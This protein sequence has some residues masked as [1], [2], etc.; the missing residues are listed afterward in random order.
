MNPSS[1]EQPLAD[2]LKAIRNRAIAKGMKLIGIDKIDAMLGRSF[3]G[4]QHDNAAG[5]VQ[6]DGSQPDRASPEPVPAAPDS[7]EGE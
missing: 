4:Q 1:S 5:Q 3:Q 2:A 7:Q 6:P